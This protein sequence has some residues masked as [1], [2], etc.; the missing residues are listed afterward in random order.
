[1]KP[2]HV[3]DP[4][5]VSTTRTT[6][7]IFTIFFQRRVSEFQNLLLGATESSVEMTAETTKRM[8]FIIF[9]ES[10]ELSLTAQMRIDYDIALVLQPTS[11]AFTRL[12]K[13]TE[14]QCLLWS[15]QVTR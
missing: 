5:P 2:N 1:M 14:T 3:A 8:Q 4:S 9:S 13:N 6:S 10:S 15:Q 7:R 12:A 11:S